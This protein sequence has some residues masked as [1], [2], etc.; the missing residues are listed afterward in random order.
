MSPKIRVPPASS[1][2]RARIMSAIKGKGN[3][4]TEQVVARLLR[5]LGFRGWRRHL[6]LPGR[7]DFAWPEYKLALFVDGCFW[8]GCPRCY[9]EPRTNVAFWREKLAANRQRDRRV[10]RMLRRH[11]WRAVRIWECAVGQA[12]LMMKLRSTLTGLRE[13]KP[14]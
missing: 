6:D 7:P 14:R 12:E 11:G 3:K 2:G 9:R 1:P 13:R 4:T 10:S 5:R 8:H